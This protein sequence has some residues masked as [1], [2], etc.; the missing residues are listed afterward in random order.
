MNNVAKLPFELS[1]LIL[2]TRLKPH[3]GTGIV[4]Y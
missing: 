1:V 3:R 2:R 4:E